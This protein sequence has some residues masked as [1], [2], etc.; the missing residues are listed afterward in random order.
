[1]LYKSYIKA[2]NLTLVSTEDLCHARTTLGNHFCFIRSKTAWGNQ[3]WAKN[4]AWCVEVAKTMFPPKKVCLVTGAVSNLRNFSFQYPR[5]ARAQRAKSR[6][7]AQNWV[8]SLHEAMKC[9]QSGSVWSTLSG[10]STTCQQQQ[11][12]LSSMSGVSYDCPGFFDIMFAWLAWCSFLQFSSQVSFAA[13]LAMKCALQNWEKSKVVHWTG[14]PIIPLPEVP[15]ADD[16]WCEVAW[17]SCAGIADSWQKW[18]RIE[19]PDRV[20]DCTA[21]LITSGISSTCLSH[22]SK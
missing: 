18:S 21:T 20:W 3:V 15:W 4:R 13:C 7:Y 22:P 14:D 10:M 5:Q 12:F 16:R 19:R 9:H 8:T 11:V 1:M 17:S 6:S 2:R